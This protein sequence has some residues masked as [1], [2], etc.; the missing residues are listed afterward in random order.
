MKVAS[1]KYKS[2]WTLILPGK[3]MGANVSLVDIGQTSTAAAS[4]YTSASTNPKSNY[5]EFA[6]S[7]V[8]LREAAKSLDMSVKEFGKPRVKLVDQTSL[9]FFSIEGA[10]P[11][12]AQL[13]AEALHQALL[14]LLDK[15]RQ[16]E[17]GQHEG[18]ALK[19]LDSYRKKLEDASKKLLE[20][21]SKSNLVSM[22]QFNRNR[23]VN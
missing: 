16:D 6:T 23:Y 22:A 5:K 15:L 7:S 10:S 14:N 2:E 12:V 21:Q 19:A 9:L 8:V 4:P 20:F 18:S 1:P 13:K 3:G 11:Q 17:I